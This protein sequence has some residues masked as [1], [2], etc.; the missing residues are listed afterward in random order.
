MK[1]FF[2]FQTVLICISHSYA[3]E[4]AIP[5]IPTKQQII[6]L[7]QAKDA[8]ESLKLYKEYIK[9]LGRH[10]FEVLQQIAS[11]I[12]EQNARGATPDKQILGIFGYSIGGLNAPP[13][14]LEQALGSSDIQVQLAAIQ[15]LARMQEDYADTL[16]NKAMSSEFLYTRLEAAFVLAQRKAKSATGQIESLMYRIPPQMRSFFPEFFAIIGTAEAIHVLRHLMDDS[17][18]P[19]RIEA[20]LSAAKHGRDDLLPAIRAAATH[21]NSA[22]QEACAAALGY[23]K[24]MKSLKKLKKLSNHTSSSVQLAALNALFILGDSEASKKIAELASEGNIFAISL[25]AHIPGEEKTLAILAKDSNMQIKFNAALSLLQRKDPRSLPP[26]L[27]FL[28]RDHRDL[29]VQPQSSIGNSMRAWK[30]ISSL[31]QKEEIALFDLR[32]LSLSMKEMILQEALELP[33]KDFLKLAQTLFEC[34]Q[35][36]LIPKLV[37]LLETLQTTE[38]I[39]LLKKHTSRLGAPLIRTYCNLALFRLGEPGPY[40]EMIQQFVKESNSQE[41]IRFRQA[42]PW[43]MRLSE[44]PFTL[45]PEESSSLLIQSY[46]ALSSQQDNESID[47]LI[48]AIESGIP[49]NRPVLAGILL[50]TLL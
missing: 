29:G 12:L 9:H 10:D 11:I 3:L 19:T 26:L 13:N 7:A 37:S 2:L 42:L 21:L 22:E 8:K 44:T 43:N 38:A 16:L 49:Q 40:K 48:E 18:H 30:V 45:T 28:I 41:L 31:K 4:E 35:N 23:L 39:D 1:T 36:D 14:I 47:I 33:E 15:F 32:S 46:E 25:L 6:Y 17:F 24:D 27:D 20:I 34:K 50:K 5:P